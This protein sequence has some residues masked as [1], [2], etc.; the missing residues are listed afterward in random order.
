MNAS[1]MDSG[2]TRG[3]RLCI[4]ARTSRPTATYFFMSGLMTVACGHARNA[5]NIG[6]AECT[7]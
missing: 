4:I 5:W 7:P 2:S 3:V 1:S 6:M